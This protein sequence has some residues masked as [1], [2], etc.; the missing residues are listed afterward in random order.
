MNNENFEL[1]NM[2]EQMNTLKSK[3][4]KQTIVNERFIRQ[5]MN[6]TASSISR[7]YYVI[8]A[9]SVLMVPYGYWVFYKMC[10]FS[11]AFWII[12]SIFMLI[13]GGATY[14][15]S[16]NVNDTNLMRS[17]LVEASRKMARAKK[18]EANWLFFGIPAVILWF[19]W[20]MYN[21]YVVNN[22]ALHEGIFWGG[23]IGGIIGSI[24]GVRIHI[25]TQREYQEIIDT[26]E[27]ITAED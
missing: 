27:D 15:N 4:D 22:D 1:E 10:G 9:L 26:I 19:S 20:F 17:N 14:Y 6:K 13:C 5:S 7:R 21:M 18:F 16:R 12:T 3:L 23:C 2:R 24:M 11:L 8:M 25:K